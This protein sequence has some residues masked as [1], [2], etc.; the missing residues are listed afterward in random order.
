SFRFFEVAFPDRKP[1]SVTTRIRAFEL[2]LS[3]AAGI[4]NDVALVP[5]TT[6]VHVLP[7]SS[8]TR[9]VLRSLSWSASFAFHATF[10]DPLT[11]TLVVLGAVRLTGGACLPAFATAT[12]VL[13]F[14]SVTVAGDDPAGSTALISWPGL[15]STTSGETETLALV[16]P[17]AFAATNV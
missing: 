17:F 10:S 13:P 5:L 11:L 3:A 7:P 6:V 8:D 2:V 16:L 1:S 15:S 14:I 9:T 4:A 12:F